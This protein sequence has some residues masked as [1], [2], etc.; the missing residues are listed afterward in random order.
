MYCDNETLRCNN[1]F[2]S[3]LGNCHINNNVVRHCE[4]HISL[5]FAISVLSLTISENA[6]SLAIRKSAVISQTINLFSYVLCRLLNVVINT[7]SYNMV[8]LIL[9]SISTISQ[10]SILYRCTISNR[11]T[12][13]R[14]TTISRRYA[15]Q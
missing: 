6:L 14:R 4:W 11:A 8:L 1:N 13:S 9:I 7:Y 5:L 10:R 3:L 15:A 2:V 12:L